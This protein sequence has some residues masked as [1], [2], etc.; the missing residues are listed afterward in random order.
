MTDRG[1]GD[2]GPAPVEGG[3]LRAFVERVERLKTEAAEIGEDIKAVVAEAKSSG[4][5][6][7]I[8]RKIVAIRAQD[9]AKRAEE[10]ELTAIYLN[11][12]A[13]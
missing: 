5:D 13:S 2:N 1:I 6:P 7:K 9:P 12:L 10:A 4:Y 3:Q 8:L 11:A